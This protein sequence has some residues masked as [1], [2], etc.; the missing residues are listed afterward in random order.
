M[1]SLKCIRNVLG[2]WQMRRK[3]SRIAGAIILNGAIR[4]TLHPDLAEGYFT[5]LGRPPSSI[6]LRSFSRVGFLVLQSAVAQRVIRVT[7]TSTFWWATW[8]GKENDMRIICDHCVRPISGTVK[9][10]AGNFNL[11]PDCLVE[12]GKDPRPR[13]KAVT[14]CSTESSMGPSLDKSETPALSLFCLSISSLQTKLLD[15]LVNLTYSQFE[16]TQ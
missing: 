7:G 9:R 5:P 4:S 13:S 2:H 8:Y 3:T 1:R 15:S 6:C 14:R 11:H 10:L 16:S 12:L